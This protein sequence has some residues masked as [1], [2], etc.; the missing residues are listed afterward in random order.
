MYPF[1]LRHPPFHL[2]INSEGRLTIRGCWR[3]FPKVTGHYGFGELARL[4][5]QDALGPSQN[6][7]V[8]GL[9]ADEVW[10]VGVRVARLINR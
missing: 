4:L 7:P 3:G 5:G 6:V 8:L 2:G 9:D 1:G 10:T